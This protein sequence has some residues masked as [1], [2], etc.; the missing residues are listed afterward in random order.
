MN[1]DDVL[2]IYISREEVIDVQ[3]ATGITGEI[4]D[5]ISPKPEAL[6]HWL[7]KS[8][9]SGNLAVDISRIDHDPLDMDILC[10]EGITLS[11]GY[12]LWNFHLLCQFLRYLS[13][14]VY[15][16]K[17]SNGFATN[18]ILAVKDHHHSEF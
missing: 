10:A 17:V 13:S 9:M 16:Q 15:I 2:V 1:F 5:T 11:N 12:L 6:S 18:K 4:I 14:S 3:F 8:M 7:H